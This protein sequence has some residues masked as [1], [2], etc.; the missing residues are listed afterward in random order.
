[1]QKE[2]DQTGESSWK[3]YRYSDS[4]E[5]VEGDEALPLPGGGGGRGWEDV[6]GGDR[7]GSGDLFAGLDVALV[8]KPIIAIDDVEVFVG[9]G[10]PTIVVPLDELVHPH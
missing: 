1:M 2:M 10:D 8:G 7:R 5:D 3:C 6:H 9:I 4:P